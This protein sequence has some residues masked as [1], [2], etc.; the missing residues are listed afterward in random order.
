MLVTLKLK[1]VTLVDVSSLP[2]FTTLKT[3]SLVSVNYPGDEFVKRIFSSC[4]AL[5][6]LVV[7]RCL[8][9]NVTIFTIIVPSLKSVNLYNG[10]GGK[11]GFL[12]DAPLLETMDI[13]DYVRD[14]CVIENAML[15]IVKAS[16]D[17]SSS[18]P[19]NILGYIT[20]VKRLFLC[21]YSTSKEVYPVGT[22]FHCLVH[23]TL[24]TCKTEWL[25]LLMYM[26]INSP[27]LLALILNQHHKLR[28]TP[29]Q[30]PCWDEPSSVP[31]CLLWSLETLE[32][33]NYE[34]TRDE[35]EVAAFILRNGSCLKKATISSKATDPSMKL[36]MIKELASSPRRSPACQ[37]I[38]D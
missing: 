11:H 5:Q 15:K 21:F 18:H 30:R 10:G 32:W 35:K 13:L 24:C 2:S 38:F 9:D 31:E 19:G 7:E 22:D 17:V 25:N 23:L 8:N 34:G 20:S 27:T 29:Q 16:V 37:L 6:D 28:A 33:V 3:L 36:E 1:S 26:R 4:H 12:I 14:F